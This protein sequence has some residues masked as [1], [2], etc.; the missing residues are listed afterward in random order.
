MFEIEDPT[1]PTPPTNSSTGTPEEPV[2]ERKRRGK[3]PKHI[4]VEAFFD[5]AQR[6]ADGVWYNGEYNQ[7]GER[8]GQGECIMPSPCFR[9][10]ASYNGQFRNN[11][12]HGKGILYPGDGSRV[13][14]VWV[15]NVI[16]GVATK[17]KP[18]VYTYVGE[19]KDEKFSGFGQLTFEPE[20]LHYIGEFKDNKFHGVGEMLCKNSGS[21]MIG[22]YEN[23]VFKK[24]ECHCLEGYIS[25]G[26]FT[27]DVCLHGPGTIQMPDGLVIEA[28][29]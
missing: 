11:K 19:F 26:Y 27:E 17:V 3:M 23:G 13:D 7:E 5:G 9:R 25:R 29:F 20:D 10:R 21:K 2:P 14:G 28:N 1:E 16:E 24:G 18:G 22:G 12:F 6:M 4:D 15:N 8:D